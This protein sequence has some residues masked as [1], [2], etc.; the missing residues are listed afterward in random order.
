MVRILSVNV[1]GL[2]NARKRQNIFH[3][4]NKHNIDITLIQETHCE[5]VEIENEWKMD[6]KGSSFWNHG[7][8]LSKGV[9]FLIREHTALTVL[10]HDIHEAGRLSS[11]KL[12]INDQNIQ[13]LNTYAPN[14]ASDR[15]RYMNRLVQYLDES[16]CHI[17]AGDFNCVLNSLLDR[18][19]ASSNRDQGSS[20]LTNLMLVYNLIDIFRKRFETK[21]SFTFSRGLSK[22]RIDYFLIS[23]L[24]D[25]KVNNAQITHFPFS[26]HDAVSIDIDMTKCKRGPGVWKMNIK[27]IFSNIFR[28]SLET[29]WPIWSMDMDSYPNPI[30]WWESIKYKV[31]HLTIEISKSINISKNK[32]MHIEKRLNDIKDSN[33]KNLIRESDFLKQ[34]IKEY[35]ENQL[36]AVKIRSRIKCFEEGEKSSKFFF[37]T[38]KKKCIK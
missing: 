25:S 35:Y 30:V 36:Q 19:P 21:Q 3:W 7:T 33:D 9:A 31:K 15:K 28:E 29:L 6:W 18:R 24:L 16:Y 22:S 34:Q 20:E 5:S 37:N 1:N 32:F 2:R 10:S 14:N 4:L 11:L 27:T 8:N 26:D 23:C 17:I 12:E 13:I 38:E